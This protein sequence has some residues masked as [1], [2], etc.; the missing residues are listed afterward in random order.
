MASNA[1]GQQ[2]G[3]PPAEARAADPP[4]Q[5]SAP[6][7]EPTFVDKARQW[8]DDTKIVERLAGT[9]DGWYPRLGGIRRGSGIGGGPGYRMHF[10]NDMLLDVSGAMSVRNY[11]AFDVRVRWLQAPAQRAELWTDYGFDDFT[12]ERF[13]GLGETTVQDARTTYGFRNN[14]V[15]LRGVLR[16]VRRLEISGRV[17]LMR[18]RLNSGS[19]TEY[20]RTNEV[21]SDPQAPGLALQPNF[22]QTQV[23]FDFDAR[24]APGYPTR[25]GFYRVAFARW[26][27]RDLNAFDFRRVDVLGT[28]YVPLTANKQHMLSGRFG[29]TSATA[30]TG[31][32][33]PFYFLPSVGG[34]DTI[35]SFADYRF[36]AEN[37][38]WYGAEYQWTPRPYV[39]LDT[40]VDLAKV[41]RTWGGLG[42]ADTKKGYGFG[43]IG[44]TSKQTLARI[45]FGFGGGEGWNVWISFGRF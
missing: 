32:R 4:P 40:F 44:H 33:V 34:S 37:V 20:R 6:P 1:S 11:K 13:F 15:A 38:L 35:R 42:S 17:A 22:V 12:E 36:S 14:T 28:H 26:D 8:A 39:S 3:S 7:P 9:T 10:G 19:D 30:D 27:D 24:D 25:G 21:L 18:P 43:V 41:A 31:A 29:F 5:P 45:D 16:P 23:A 2:P